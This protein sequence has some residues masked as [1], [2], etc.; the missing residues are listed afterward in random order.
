MAEELPEKWVCLGYEIG[1]ALPGEIGPSVGLAPCGEEPIGDSLG[2]HV[3]ELF[4]R[5]VRDKGLLKGFALSVEGS[6]FGFRLKGRDYKVS[7][8]L[9]L[10][11]HAD[12]QGLRVA[13]G[14]GLMVEEMLEELPDGSHAFPVPPDRAVPLDP[15]QPFPQAALPICVPAKLHKVG[16]NEI[17]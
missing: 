15:P 4:G 8:P 5:E 1:G 2:V 7:Y 9:G 3:G 12:R 6:R 13:D 10:A 16:E 11:R 14:L 17:A